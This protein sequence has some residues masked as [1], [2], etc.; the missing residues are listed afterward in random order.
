MAFFAYDYQS[1]FVLENG[2][3]ANNQE[4]EKALQEETEERQEEQ[5]DQKK[6]QVIKGVLGVGL[7]SLIILAS[8]FMH[9]D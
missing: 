9:G 2:E 6:R 4:E 3:W 5:E 1:L 8:L 7:C